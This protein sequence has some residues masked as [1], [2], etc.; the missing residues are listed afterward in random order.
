MGRAR[1][2]LC[3][4]VLSAA[5]SRAEIDHDLDRGERV[6]DHV[7][8]SV[9]SAKRELQRA[10][11]KMPPPAQVKAEIAEAKRALE[12]KLKVAREELKIELER[13]RQKTP[14]KP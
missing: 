12:L 10:K 2:W 13:A 4:V 3:A 6:V 8:E 5:C 14:E 9:E 11:E 7:Q 1:G